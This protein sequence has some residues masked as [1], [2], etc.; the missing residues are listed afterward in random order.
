LLRIAL[1]LA[2]VSSVFVTLPADS[3]AP[4]RLKVERNRTVLTLYDAVLEAHDTPKVATW[5]MSAQMAR[6]TPWKV[7]I[8]PKGS[9]I[10]HAVLTS[11]GGRLQ[12]DAA[13]RHAVAAQV[14]P[15]ANRLEIVFPHHPA[16]PT[17][18]KIANGVSY[19]EGQRWTGG[20]PARV[21]TLRVDPKRAE[22]RP[23]MAAPGKEGKM[24]LE[25]VSRIVAR[26]KAI[27]GINGTFFSPAT[28][29]PLG[30]LVVDGQLVSSQLYNRSAFYLLKDGRSMVSNANLMAQVTTPDGD[31]LQPHAVNQPAARH[32]LTL[33]TDHYG[34]K[35][36]TWPDPSRWEV[37]LSPLGNIVN[38]GSGNLSIPMGGVVLSAQGKERAKLMQALSPGSQSK[39]T[40]SLEKSGANVAHVI[41]GGPT[42]VQKG[43]VRITAVEERFRNDVSQGRAPRTAL[44]VDAKGNILL[45]TVDGRQ[46][47]YSA[48]MT[49]RELARTLDELGA[50]EA[51]NLDGGGS[52]TMALKGD[53]VNKPSDGRERWVSNA[54]IVTPRTTP[55]PD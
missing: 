48:G 7:T 4:Y 46:P 11:T 24:G 47:G 1:T 18:S 51:I 42:L 22:V 30:L 41:G 32:Q 38:M 29:E 15:H 9:V 50:Q 53:V 12:I 33:Y 20:G 3:A 34:F 19:W 45:A 6:K 39:V 35:S 8:E 31:F 23:A 5:H 36:R 25:P 13:W 26:N 27:A 43:K 37:A 52:T 44:G 49:L 21:R 28:M 16:A 17:Y 10:R 54:L 14:I 2:L 55:L 40:V